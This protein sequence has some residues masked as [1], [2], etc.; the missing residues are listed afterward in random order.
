MV[1]FKPSKLTLALLSTGLMVVSSSSFAYAE[2]A[3]DKKKAAEEVEVIEVTGIRSS[4]LSALD[5]KRTSDVV[6]DFIGAGD[7]GVLPDP[8]IADS[9]GRLSGVTTV[10][11]SGQSS[12]LNIRGMNGDFIQT[13]LNGREQATTSASTES[14][15]WMAFDQY[16]AELI[17]EAAVYKSPKASHIEGGVA[18]TVELKTANPLQAEEDHNFTASVRLSHNDAAS[19]VGAD[20]TGHKY[21]FTYQGKFLDETLGLALGYSHLTQPNNFEGSRAAAD[22]QLGYADGNFGGTDAKYARAYQFQAGAGEDK[23]DGL[24]AAVVYQPNESLQVKFDYLRSEY[25][26]GDIRHGVTIGGLQDLSTYNLTNVGVEGVGINSSTVSLT[27]P[28]TRW[29]SSPWFESRTE[30]QSTQADSD[31]F[32]LNITYQLTERASII[33]DLAH[34]EGKKTRKDRIVSL[35]AYEFGTATGLDADGNELTQE[36]WQELSGQQMTFVGNGEETP[37]IALNYDMTDLDLMRLSR[38]EEYP[39]VYTDEIDSAKVDFMYEF[40]SGFIS[41]IELGARYSDRKFDSKRGTFLYGSRDGQFRT[42]DADGNWEEYCADNLTNDNMPC[43][44]QSVEGFTSVGSVNGAPDHLVV[45]MAGLADHLFGAGN[46]QGKQVFSRDWTFV[47]S[48]GVE[49][50]V[51]AFYAMANFSTEIGDV[52]V[53]GN[54]GVRYVDSDVKSIGVQNVGAGNGVP[55]T[56]DVGVTQNNYDY[57]DYGPEFDDVLPSINLNFELTEND[58]V[59]VAA[60]EV[61][62]RPPVGQLKG[63]AGSWNSGDN[64]DVYNV[65][66]KGSPYLDP[67]RAKQIDI[68]YE[69]YFEE[70]GA[71]T[72]AVFYKDIESL[73]TSVS[74]GADE[75]W[76]GID[77]PAGTTKG[78]YNTFKNTD[79][80]GYIRGL[81][82]AATKTFDDLPG[83][84]SGL[85]FNANYSY[86]ESEASIGGGGLFPEQDLPLPGLSKNVWSATLFWDIGSFSTYANVRYRDDY[87]FIMPVPGSTTPVRAK[88]YT[89]VDWQASY[90]FEN[91]VSVVLQVNNLTDEANK[92]DYGVNSQLGE[93]KTFGRQMY[94]GVDYKF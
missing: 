6:G 51:M 12:Q 40:D 44:P 90:A 38:Y 24:I 20:E 33:V 9:L 63:G 26:S 45:N 35:G 68:S 86:T 84:F 58:I 41:S 19:D 4:I 25:E 52:P 81:E 82:L 28:N 32:G 5:A 3:Q 74:R 50:K 39:H 46:Y 89:T 56:D 7:L 29:D 27:D 1:N 59:R 36:F 31:A 72:A 17:T 16:P 64:G 92:V 93:Y 48:G 65:W 83:V 61:M 2:E 79:D 11:E 37:S 47:E 15:R 73:I 42:L 87:I 30:D 49:E 21:S 54:F 14:S 77:L 62:A 70:G 22:S 55:I 88:E 8:S 76:P 94:L 18:G 75:E 60:A 66:S 13:T 80:G 69:H 53:T 91:G 71:V 85:G 10:R 34:S 67:F 23:R 43:M 78:V 57:L